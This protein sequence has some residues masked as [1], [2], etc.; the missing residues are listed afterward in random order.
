MARG[1]LRVLLGAAPGVGKTFAM[2]EEGHQL[3]AARRDVVVGVVETHG[4]AGT[5]ALLDGFEQVATRGVQH[6]GVELQELDLDAVLRR[7]PEVALIDELAHTNAPGGAHEK[8]WQDVAALLDAGIDVIST[9]N[10]QHLESLGDVVEQITGVRQRETVPDAVLRDAD[11]VELVDL[12][13]QALR[14]RLEAGEVYPAARV[15]A[16]LSNYFRLGNLTA[17]RE[18]ALLWLADEVDQALQRYR[19]QQGIDATWETRERVVVALTG[20]PEGETLLKRGA[21]IAARSS[22]GDLLAVHVQRQD[23]LVDRDLAAIT[24]QRALVERLGGSFHT[25]VG[26]DVP[27]A[28]VQFA[29]ASH[30][31]QLVVGASRRGWL[32]TALTGPGIGQ[33]VVRESGDIDVHT[34]AHAAAARGRRLPSLAHA[35][36]SGRRQL[37]GWALAVLGVPM[38]TWMLDA[39]SEQASVT[40]DALLLQLW[41]VVV[42]L[43]GGIWAATFAAL[44]AGVLFLVVLVE[45]RFT[46][47]VAEPWHVVAVVVLFVSALLVSWVVDRA[48]R[49]TRAAGRSAAESELLAAISSGVLGGQGSIQVALTRTREALGLTG[50]R[51]LQGERVVALDG[52]PADGAGESGRA[53]TTVPVGDDSMLELHGRM[54]D[55]G[56]RRILDVV[57]HQLA[58]SLRHRSVAAIASELE[59]L[60]AQDRVRSALLRAVSHDLR[61]PL[62]AATASVGALRSSTISLGEADR[63]ELLATAGESLAT[64]GALVTDLLDVSRIDAGALAVATRAIDVEDAIAPALD[65]VGAS[66][67]AIALKLGAVP[68]VVADPVL[69]QRV[70]VNLLSNAMRHS[71]AR[72]P[73]T[74]VASAFGEAVEVRIADRGPGIAPDER[75][76]AFVPFQRLGDTDNDTGLGL[77][78]AL[79]RGFAEAMGGELAAETTPGGGLTMVVRL[80]RA[81]DAGEAG[82]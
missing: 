74:I 35:P 2:L 34:V 10:V 70:L 46:F 3:L 28:L 9:V 55:A 24:A 61:R 76:R 42:A 22:G 65:E 36:L 60:A 73:V 68:Q 29:R 13:P 4:R 6:R 56:E 41:V 50:V 23:G 27:K 79:S 26:D 12:Q 77:G 48:A 17:L 5:A 7:A 59:P 81:A 58:A 14:A 38:L 18:L 45:P 71:P 37:A 33:A 57:V 39:G 31:T 49:T 1:A 62:A 20:G 19:E 8:R 80:R 54:L 15:D 67:D 66:P 78:L 16:A 51:L 32:Q 53:P 40:A 47:V 25:V 21:R 63:A 75:D 64:L 30:A 72:V 52:E 69:L 82:S 11:R 43:V 44:L